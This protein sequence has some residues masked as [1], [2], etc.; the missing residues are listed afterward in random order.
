MY[1]HSGIKEYKD[2]LEV[3]LRVESAYQKEEGRYVLGGSSKLVSVGYITGPLVFF[4]V[5]N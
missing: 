5:C 3:S 1:N 4:F 2:T